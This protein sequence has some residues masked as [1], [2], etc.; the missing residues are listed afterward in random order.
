MALTNA[1]HQ[2]NWRDARRKE[3]EELAEHKAEVMIAALHGDQQDI[4]IAQLVRLGPVRF[5]K[6]RTKY[7]LKPETQLSPVAER[8]K[9]MR[10]RAGKVD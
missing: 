2:K 5:V 7:G 3:R 10:A 8:V 1:Q 6:Y 4:A 9:A